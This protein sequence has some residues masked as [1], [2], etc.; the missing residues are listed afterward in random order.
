M[1]KRKTILHKWLDSY[2]YRSYAGAVGALSVTFLFAIYNG[3]LG[4]LYSSLWHGTI[5]VYYLLLVLVRGLIVF[6][7]K[8]AVRRENAVR[9]R[10]QINVAVSAY[11]IPL[12][13]CLIVPISMMVRHQKPV[14]LSLTAGIAVA[15]YTTFKVMM[16]SLHLKRRT[17]SA[18]CLVRNLRMINFIDALVS[19]LSLQ[20]TLVMILSESP[21]ESV[22]LLTEISSGVVW[23][24][25]LLISIF[26]LI[27]AVR[28]LIDGRD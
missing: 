19:I 10:I 18:N 1:N 27:H 2:D 16:A 25:I 28:L 7:E 8:V 21:E 13:L 15:A 6:A 22:T 20:N 23:L 12:N 14:E 26:S 24:S 4:I 11:L 9:W 5:C 17:M 3:Y